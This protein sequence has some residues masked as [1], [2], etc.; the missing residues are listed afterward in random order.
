M[1]HLEEQLNQNSKNSSQLPSTDQ[2]ANRS[3]WAKVEN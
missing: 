3:L 2:K 1:A